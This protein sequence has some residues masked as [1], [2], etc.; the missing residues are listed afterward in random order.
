M[1]NILVNTQY[2]GTSSWRVYSSIRVNC[3]IRAEFWRWITIFM[4]KHIFLHPHSSIIFSSQWA[5]VT[6]KWL[7]TMQ[8]LH[9]NIVYTEFVPELWTIEDKRF[10]ARNW[11]FW[12]ATCNYTKWFMIACIKHLFHRY[13]GAQ[14]GARLNPHFLLFSTHYLFQ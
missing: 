14:C 10:L 7:N 2:S 3:L 6:R 5:N 11:T 1:T 12:N 9:Q 4:I 13:C 8:F